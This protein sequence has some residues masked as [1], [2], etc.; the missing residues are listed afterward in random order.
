MADDLSA[1]LRCLSLSNNDDTVTLSYLQQLACSKQDFFRINWGGIA[2]KNCDENGTLLEFKSKSEA[3]K[4]QK[5]PWLYL[6]LKKF[7]IQVN[8]KAFN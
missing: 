4:S 6:P 2:L 5:L 1:A 3:A 8:I 7:K